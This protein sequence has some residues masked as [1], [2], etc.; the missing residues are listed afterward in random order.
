[1]KQHKRLCNKKNVEKQNLIANQKINNMQN[2]NLSA[3]QIWGKVVVMLREKQ[4]TILHIVCGDITNIEKNGTTLV[5][6]TREQSVYTL[7]NQPSNLQILTNL[8]GNFGICS[9]KVEFVQSANNMTQN[10]EILKR[11]FDQNITIKE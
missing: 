8:L 7:L 10:I 5:A 4:Q 6:T 11:F 3:K 9:F 1:M 2:L